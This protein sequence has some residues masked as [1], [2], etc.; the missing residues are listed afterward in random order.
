MKK[1]RSLKTVIITL[2]LAF[3]CLVV[4][5]ILPDDEI[6]FN[7]Q[8]KPIINNNCISC[9]GGVRQNG[10]FS[11][12]FEEQAK[13][14]TDSGVPA[15]IPGHPEKSEMIRRL[16]S[17]DLEERMPYEK[18]PLGKEEINILKRWIKEG[19]KWD[20]HWAYI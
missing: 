7:T 4:W 2:L 8:V 12:L 9:H 14:N 19:A 6:D 11:L 16:Q 20:T 13:G 10:G 1:L 18:K 17:H 3:S 5:V 15:I